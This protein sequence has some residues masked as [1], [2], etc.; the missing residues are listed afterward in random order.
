MVGTASDVEGERSPRRGQNGL[1]Q[2][3]GHCCHEGSHDK[4]E[5]R[6]PSAKKLWMVYIRLF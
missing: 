3:T 5:A 1:S 6:S 2:Q 4:R